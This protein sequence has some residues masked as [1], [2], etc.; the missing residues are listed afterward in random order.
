MK[1]SLVFIVITYIVGSIPFGL[2]FSKIKGIDIRKHGSGNIGATNVARVI[3]KGWGLFTLL[4]D[5]LKGYLPI[6]LYLLYYAQGPSDPLPGVLGLFAVCGHCF[7]IFLKGRGGKGVAT[8][9]GVFLAFSPKAFLAPVL[10]FIISVKL[11]GFVSV[12]S[13]L[14]SASAPISM[15]LNGASPFIEPFL[16][17]IVLVIWFQHRSNIKRL[18]S[19]KEMKI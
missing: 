16:W 17:L 9:A 14:A 18:L 6:K 13:L 12:G 2:L 7:S 19:G 10:I 8:A 1:T 4:L 5:F 3:G 15:H 11:S